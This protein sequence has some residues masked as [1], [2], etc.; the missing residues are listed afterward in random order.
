MRKESLESIPCG[1]TCSK[2]GQE[3]LVFGCELLQ[4]S[5]TTGDESC[6][7]GIE[8]G[9]YACQQHTHYP[10]LALLTILTKTSF[11]YSVLK[12]VTISAT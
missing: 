6:K 4:R 11:V 7:V 9:L 12:N 5:Y 3:G 2:K 10:V 1:Q 8:G